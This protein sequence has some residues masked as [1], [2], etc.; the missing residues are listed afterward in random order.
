[1]FAVLPPPI[2]PS[3]WFFGQWLYLQLELIGPN[4][5][6]REAQAYKYSSPSRG[7]SGACP[8]SQVAALGESKASDWTCE[9]LWGPHDGCL[10]R[11]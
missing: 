9:V 7:K 2:H 8:T 5:L 1:M 10:G 3:Q 4:C 6:Q 11:L